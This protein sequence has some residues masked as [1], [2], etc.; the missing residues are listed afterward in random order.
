MFAF[1]SN[2]NGCLGIGGAEPTLTPR[3]L[4]PLCKKDLC[5]I[6]FGTG[7]HVLAATENGEMYR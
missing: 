5:E 4:E 3:K 7:P 1:G 2:Y 6:A